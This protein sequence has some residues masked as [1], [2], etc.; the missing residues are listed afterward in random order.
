M[1]ALSGALPGMAILMLGHPSR[2]LNSEFSGSSAWENV[3]RTRLYLGASLP[4]QKQEEE[5]TPDTRYLSRR[6]SNY[7]SKDWRRCS[8][9][10]GVLMP[11]WAFA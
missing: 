3:A 1:N 8:F 7:S 5:P 11:R 4:D 10:D 2:G 6:K 9:K